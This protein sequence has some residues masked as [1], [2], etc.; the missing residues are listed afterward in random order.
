MANADASVVNQDIDATHEANRIV[1]CGL[2]LTEVRNIGVDGSGQ[3]RQLLLD[4]LATFGIT[5]EH[6]TAEPSSRKRAAVAAPMPLAPP[7][8]STRLPS[9]PRIV[10]R[11]AQFQDGTDDIKSVRRFWFSV[12]R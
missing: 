7:V 10:F 3:I 4:L 2:H 6:A 1:E 5:I 11:I 12:L 9:S 8:T